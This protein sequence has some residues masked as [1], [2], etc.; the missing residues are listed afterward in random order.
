MTHDELQAIILRD[1][2][3]GP[4]WFTGPQ[5][6]SALAAR[7]RRALLVDLTE[8]QNWSIQYQKRE[9]AELIDMVH[10]ANKLKFPLTGRIFPEVLLWDYKKHEKDDM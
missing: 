6:F 8:L 7:D 5:S 2:E 1:A 4:L 9:V 10:G 3:T